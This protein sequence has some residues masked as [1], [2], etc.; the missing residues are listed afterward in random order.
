MHLMRT[1]HVRA[2]SGLALAM[3]F[4]ACTDA[5]PDPLGLNGPAVGVSMV[6]GNN[7]I[8]K[9]GTSLSQPLVVSVRDGNG[10]PV[11]AREVILVCQRRNHHGGGRFNRR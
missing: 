3:S 7:Q 2:L 9:F 8:G 11:P 4:G 5:Q 1:R 6:S 10:Q